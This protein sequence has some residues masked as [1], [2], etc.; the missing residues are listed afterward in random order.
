MTPR[1]SRS[2]DTPASCARCHRALRPPARAGGPHGR[3]PDGR[4]VAVRLWPEG[5]VCS[6]CYATACETYGSCPA[7]GLHR[8]LP[9]RDSTGRTVCTDCAGGIGDF[10]CTLCGNEGWNHYRGVCGRC[11]LRER[12]TS[13][14]ADTTGAVPPSLLPLLEYL[15]AMPRPRT[16]ILWLTKPHTHRLLSALAN[17]QV[18]L[19][20]PGLDQLGPPKAVAHLR[21]LLIA[22]GTL[23]QI[24]S[25]LHRTTT[26]AT[27]YIAGITLSLIHI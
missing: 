25:T 14:M 24:D 20:H 1:G 12:L 9:G 15:C 5:P 18:P 21:H 23:P 26:W 19:T 22:A 7:C 27:D 6:G 16:G 10:T 11:V 17:G 4:V 2:E 3:D 13:A 8:L